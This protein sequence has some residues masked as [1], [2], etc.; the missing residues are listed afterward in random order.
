MGEE[1]GLEAV[2]RADLEDAPGAGEPE[3]FDHLRH[4]RGLG[5]H[6]AVGY[7][8]RP[9]QVGLIGELE[10]DEVGPRHGSQ[11]GEEPGVTRPRGDCRPDQ[12]FGGSHG[13]ML[14][15]LPG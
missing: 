14:G 2:A 7:R 9:V 11:G 15:R 6:L 4:E 3:R 1:C 8:Q 12:V 10:R 5:S 13:A